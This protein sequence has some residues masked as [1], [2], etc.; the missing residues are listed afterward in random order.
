MSVPVYLRLLRERAINLGVEG[1]V[2]LGSGVIGAAINAKGALGDIPETR[3][4]VRIGPPPCGV[5][6]PG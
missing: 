5:A 6:W 2:V 4:G 1:E 3:G